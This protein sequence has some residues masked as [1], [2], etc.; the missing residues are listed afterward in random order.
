MEKKTPITY[1]NF[2]LGKRCRHCAAKTMNS[3]AS[4]LLKRLFQQVNISVV[5]EKKFDDCRNPMT[6]RHLPFD[7]YIEKTNTL[8]EIDGEQHFIPVKQWGGEKKLKETKYRDYIK[9]KYCIEN[10]INLIRV[11]LLDF[12]TGKKKKYD[13][14][15]QIIFNLLN[16]LSLDYYKEA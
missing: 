8:I 12:E 15:K 6:E 4:Q 10:N 3:K 2:S 7:F 11:S 5:E 14:V 9:D 1:K 16:D 13:D